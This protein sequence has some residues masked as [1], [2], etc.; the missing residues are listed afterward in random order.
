MIWETFFWCKK[1]GKTKHK[2]W[3][4]KEVPF[5]SLQLFAKSHQH[6]ESKISRLLSLAQ[7]MDVKE[8]FRAIPNLCDRTQ[9]SFLIGYQSCH[10][11]LF[12]VFL[13]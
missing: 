1:L 7:K 4:F 8:T 13:N 10:D 6:V 9:E 12:D 11:K 3:Y 2:I 5:F